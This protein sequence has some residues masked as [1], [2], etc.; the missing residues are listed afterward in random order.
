MKTKNHA[1]F[2]GALHARGEKCHSSVNSWTESYRYLMVNTLGTLVE[3]IATQKNISHPEN[4]GD[5][6]KKNSAHAHPRRR[7]GGI[8]RSDL[9][10]NRHQDELV[11]YCIHDDDLEL[12]G[13]CWINKSLIP[14][15]YVSFV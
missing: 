9:P 7:C 3:I 11:E 4:C 8:I 15:A 2:L 12:V 1:P 14:K 10:L 5:Q 6:N 13:M